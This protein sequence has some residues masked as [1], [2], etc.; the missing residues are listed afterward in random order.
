MGSSS[1]IRSAQAASEPAADPLPGPTG[2]PR[3]LAALMKSETTRK[4][5]EKPMLRITPSS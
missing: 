4:Y 2:I 3:D 1:V 5:P